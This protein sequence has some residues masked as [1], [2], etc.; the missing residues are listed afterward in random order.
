MVVP[1]LPY[2]VVHRIEVRAEHTLVILGS[3][4]EHSSGPANHARR[5]SLEGSVLLHL[6]PQFAHFC[7]T[8]VQRML[9]STVPCRQALSLLVT[10]ARKRIMRPSSGG[11][12]VALVML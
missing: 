9:S 1:G 8:G 10:V 4:M 5:M 6:T 12:G 11:L 3:T 7:R 2:I